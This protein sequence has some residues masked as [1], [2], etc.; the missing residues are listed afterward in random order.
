MGSNVEINCYSLFAFFER[1]I[2]LFLKYLSMSDHSVQEH[3]NSENNKKSFGGKFVLPLLIIACLFFLFSM[4]TKN[5]SH[6]PHADPHGEEH[7]MESNDG[8]MDPEGESHNHE[9]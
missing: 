1:H 7:S 9:H 4:L 5:S 3:D 2:Y 6:D 8:H